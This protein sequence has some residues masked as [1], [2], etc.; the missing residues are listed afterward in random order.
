MDKGTKKKQ[1]ITSNPTIMLNFA[2][3][4]P[5]NMRNVLWLGFLLM[6]FTTGHAQHAVGMKPTSAIDRHAVVE[7]NSPRICSA[8]ALSSLTVG[9]GHFATTVDVTGLQS[10]PKEYRAGVPLN[11]MSDWGWHSFP[12]T[13]HLQP[14]ESEQ[15]YDFGH[16]HQ[17]VYAVE[18]KKG[19][20]P[21]QAT[22]YYRVNPHRLNL[23]TIGLELKDKQGAVIPLNALTDIR[24]EQHLWD[25]EIAS[26]FAAGGRKV[27][28]TTGV[29]PTRD[30]L[31][32]RISSR[33]LANRQ[34]VVTLRFSYPT[35]GHADDAND[36]TRPERHQSDIIM[37]DSHSAL[38]LHRLDST[39]YYVHIQ[40]EGHATLK[41][42]VTHCF[43]LST[44]DNV[45]SFSAEYSAE[46]IRDATH[47]DFQ[48]YHATTRQHWHRWWQQGGFVDFSACTDP[49]AKELERRVVLSQYLMQVN[50]ANNL[51]PQE[52]GLTYNTWYGRPH[53]EM[54]WW[55]VLQFALWNRPEAIRQMLRWYHDTAYPVARQIAQRQGFRGVRWMKM[56]DPWAGE[57][58]SNTGSFLIWQQPHYI[59]LAEEMYRAAPTPATLRQY[60]ELVEATAEFM[61]DFV[62]YDKTTGRYIIKGATAMQECMTKDI[63][64]NQ[65][66]ELAYWQY[67][68]SVAQQWRERQGKP[69]HAQ[70]DD[71]IARLSPLPEEQGI[72][73]AGIPL[74][75]VGEMAAFDPFGHAGNQRETFSEK[76]RRDHPAV[77]GA[78]GL[79]PSGATPYTLL[80][81]QETM[82]LTLRWV[83]EH[84]NWQTTWG[85][86]YGM[87][88]MA[89][90][91]L[92]NP[93]AALDA[94]LIDTQKNTYLP[95]GHNFQTPDRLRVYLPGNG[96]LL[97]AIA[98]MCA[99]WDG[100]TDSPTPGFPKDGKWNVRWEDLRP[101]Q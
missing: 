47:F 45:L 59:Y 75:T 99:G 89:A 31:Y 80:Y 92:G 23:G 58:P 88:A 91:R 55:H 79:L 77:L 50:C 60:G 64:Y 65:P 83:M 70:W 74:G 25:G 36:W 35:G 37:Q 56:T 73:T 52:S 78:C 4:F 48:Q 97:T 86:D 57:A 14:S 67:G 3:N 12:N 32:A 51:P 44:A 24:Q 68:L 81:H 6:V 46:P 53:L 17:E 9:N 66:F 13:G 41:K 69:R 29:H 30:A 1:N 49:R 63:A 94:L 71:I 5:S 34:A 100:S 95:N 39:T 42:R 20:R 61:A 93:E 33:L 84:W 54:T 7:R 15:A 85:W 96:A 2:A 18:Y 101:M 87:I 11:T 28:V 21:Q 62:S 16:G 90:A 72:Y 40:W 38:I 98:M 82:R 10:Y 22:T 19:G 8:D 43:E 76:C 27:E 26:S